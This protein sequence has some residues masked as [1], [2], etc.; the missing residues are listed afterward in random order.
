VEQLAGCEP[1]MAMLAES[2]RQQT[3]YC[4]SDAA[5]LGCVVV[6]VVV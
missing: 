4:V 5:R 3:Q 2:Q 1:Y 6:L